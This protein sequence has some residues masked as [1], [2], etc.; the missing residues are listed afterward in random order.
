MAE[1]ITGRSDYNSSADVDL[2]V[3]SIRKT[4]FAKRLYSLMME[5]NWNQSDLARA[6]NI[7]RDSVSQY[8]RANNI[9]SPQNLK[10]L[11]GALG[12]EPVE[13]YPNYEAAAIEE[14][15]PSLSFRQMPGDEEYMWVRINKKLPRAVAA[16]IMVLLNE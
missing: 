1:R 6:S 9:P 5:K 15:I 2:S 14:E 3:R 12:V 8:I 10:K 4:E 13:L 7:G 16:Q 11:A